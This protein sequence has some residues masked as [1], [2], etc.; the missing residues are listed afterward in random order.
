MNGSIVMAGNVKLCLL[1]E[2]LP[3]GMAFQEIFRKLIK[4]VK[5]T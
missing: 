5:N 2:E 3:T 1:S 4:L